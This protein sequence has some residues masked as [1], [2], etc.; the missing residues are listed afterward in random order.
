MKASWL[1]SENSVTSH[2]S[3]KDTLWIPASVISTTWGLKGLIHVNEKTST[4]ILID[5]ESFGFL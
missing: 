1:S 4:A 2:H 5:K 3:S